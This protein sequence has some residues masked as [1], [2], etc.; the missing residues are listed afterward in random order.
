MV[1]RK[2]I[3]KKLITYQMLEG[4]ANALLKRRELLVTKMIEVES[5]LNSLDDIKKGGG[6]NILFPV[7]SGIHVKGTLKK[8]DKMVVELGSNTAIENT[9]QKTKQIL[10]KRKKMLENGLISLENEMVNIN[11]EL[12][13]LQP[14]IRAI[15]S[16]T[17]KSSSD[18]AAG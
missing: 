15:L 18:V 2:E 6:E 4:K 10:Q 11:K 17:K 9:V 5:T 3:Q 12:I 1:E 7:G 8:V 16:G 13:K 14:E